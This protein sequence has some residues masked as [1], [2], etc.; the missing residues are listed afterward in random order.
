MN[1]LITLGS[2]PRE[3]AANLG[4]IVT[5]MLKYFE[6]LENFRAKLVIYGLGFSSSVLNNFFATV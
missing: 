1:G 5:T 3:S 4:I 2:E 6:F